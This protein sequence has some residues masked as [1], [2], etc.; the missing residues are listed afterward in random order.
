MLDK[1]KDLLIKQGITKGYHKKMYVYYLQGLFAGDGNFNV[2]KNKMNGNHLRLIFY[3]EKLDYAK[4]AKKLL[5]KIGLK[6][7]IKKDSRKNMYLIKATLNW[8]KILL[9]QKLKIFDFHEKHKLR[10]IKTI[11]NHKRYKSHKHIIKL[12]KR[13]NIT[14]MVETSR[15]DK[16]TCYNWARKMIECKLVIKNDKNDWSLTEKGD[17]VKNILVGL[18]E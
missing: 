8:K 18:N 4:E 3:E 2:F 12:K 13:F 10:L 1:I 17:E 6:N 16:T 11:K 9:L 14:D 7:K 5:N 15:K